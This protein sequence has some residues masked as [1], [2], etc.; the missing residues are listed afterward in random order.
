MHHVAVK[1]LSSGYAIEDEASFD[2]L[3][4]LVSWYTACPV[5]LSD[6]SDSIVLT[7]AALPHMHTV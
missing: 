2:H 1:E 3:S 4:D 5:P 6:G 7:Y